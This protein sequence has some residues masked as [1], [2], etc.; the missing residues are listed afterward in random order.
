MGQILIVIGVTN[1]IGMA[2]DF[3]PQTY[4]RGR[5]TFDAVNG[6]LKAYSERAMR[7]TIGR[8]PD[9]GYAV[10]DLFELTPVVFT[11]PERMLREHGVYPVSGLAWSGAGKV[12]RVEVSADGGDSWAEA[13]LQ[14]PVLSKSTTRF[15]IPLQWRG[16]AVTLQSRVTDESGYR[17]PTRDE[18]LKQRGRQG[19]FHYHA[20]NS[21]HIDEDG[22]VSHVYA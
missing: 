1:R 7:A 4:R 12:A 6:Q 20:I 15:R 5:E 11:L 13:L 8:I 9:G 14:E 10:Q 21:W 22:F 17:Q 18:L 19:Y 16:Q 3:N 2:G